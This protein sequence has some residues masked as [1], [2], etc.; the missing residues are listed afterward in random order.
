MTQPCHKDTALNQQCCDSKHK[1]GGGER[2]TTFTMTP[3]T[4]HTP[5]SR[6]PHTTH[7]TQQPKEKAN[8][9]TRGNAM[10]GGLDNAGYRIQFEDREHCEE[11]EGNTRQRGNTTHTTPRHST[12]PLSKRKGRTPTLDGRVNAAAPPFHHHATHH[13]NGTPPSTIAPPTIHDEGGANRGYPTTRTPQTHTHH[14]H[15]TH[16]AKN[17]ARHDSSTDEYC[18]GMSRARATPLHWA[19]Q[20]QYTPPPFHTPRRMDTIHSSTHLLS[21]CSRSHNQRTIMINEQ[22][23]MF[24]D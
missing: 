11:D 12:G 6:S 21:H 13:R 22:Q 3:H 18:N 17:S 1:D 7:H 20:Q 8:S 24:N 10:Q 4:P 5:P 14:P 15:T 2:N 23:S 16:P 9:T 19:G